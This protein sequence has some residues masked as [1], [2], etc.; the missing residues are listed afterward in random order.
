MDPGPDSAAPHRCSHG[1]RYPSLL[2][3]LTPAAPHR[4]LPGLGADRV[5]LEALGPCQVTGGMP[6]PAVPIP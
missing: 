6:A 2:P 3:A 1:V 5:T 4:W